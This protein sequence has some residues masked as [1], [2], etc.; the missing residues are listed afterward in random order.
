RPTHAGEHAGMLGERGGRQDMVA[1]LVCEHFQRELFHPTD[2]NRR[3]ADDNRLVLKPNHREATGETFLVCRFDCK[4]NCWRPQPRELA[5]DLERPRPGGFPGLTQGL[6]LGW[7]QGGVLVREVHGPRRANSVTEC[8][9]SEV[10]ARVVVLA[11][12]LVTFP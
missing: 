1:N 9:K 12:A 10:S 5:P 4:A 3:Q 6:Q 2:D 11:A 8:V 7:S